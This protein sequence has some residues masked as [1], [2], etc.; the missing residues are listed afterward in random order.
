M[1]VPCIGSRKM[2][3]MKKI[4]FPALTQPIRM[5]TGARRVRN[6]HMQYMNRKW[7]HQRLAKH[8]PNDSFVFGFAAGLVI[9]ILSLMAQVVLTSCL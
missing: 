2:K 9:D 8:W 1:I 3:E 7:S 5:A 4:A 6:T